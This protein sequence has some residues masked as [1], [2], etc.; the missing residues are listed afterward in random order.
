MGCSQPT[1]PPPAQWGRLANPGFENRRIKTTLFFAGQARDGSDPYGCHPAPN[2]SLYTVHPLDARHLHWSKDPANRDW[3]LAGMAEAGID[4]VSMS[5]WGE[6]S[7]PCHEGWALSAPMQTAPAAH[8]ELF[9]AAG[10]KPLLIM[11]LLESRDGWAP[12]GQGRPAGARH[13]RTD[14][15]PDRSLPQESRTP[16]VG[17]SVGPRVRPAE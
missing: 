12:Q 7:L 13:R 9:A 15:R 8:D 5:S 16:G 10:G 2:E 14:Q 1:A 3:A 6:Q 17:Q 11:P 4:V